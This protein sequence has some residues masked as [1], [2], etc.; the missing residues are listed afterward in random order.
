M[1]TLKT[2][3]EIETMRRGGAILREVM[4][5]LTAR[6]KPGVT[7]LELDRFAHDEMIR[8]K[9]KPAFLGLY[10]FPGSVCIS[11]NEEI[12]HGIPGPRR[13]VEGDIVSLDCGLIYEG[14]YLDTA[15]TAPVGKTDEDSLRLIRTAS[16]ALEIGIEWL[17]PGRRLG[18]VSAAIQQHVEREGFS[19]VREYTGHGVGRKLHE[20]PKIPNHGQAGVGRRWQ[21]GMT[22]CIEPMVNGGGAGTRLL[23]DEWTVVTADGTRSAHMEHTVAITESGPEVL[24]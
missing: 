23:A 22:V 11:V 13:L 7:T 3:Q 5:L 17:V 2:P 9:T 19:V 16:E 4:D 6:V 8:R 10:G 1:I 14:F 12:V 20:D 15:R 24:T 21:A 18:D